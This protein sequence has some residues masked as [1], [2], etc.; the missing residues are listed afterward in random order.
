[1]Q[2]L[3]DTS[4]VSLMLREA[5]PR[6]RKRLS[7]TPMQDLC[8]S[9][10]TEAELRYGLARRGHPAGL[11]QRVHELLLRLESLPWTSEVAQ[12]YAVLRSDSDAAGISLGPLDMMIAAHARAVDATL[13]SA[14]RAFAR[15]H[16]LLRVQDWSD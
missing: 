14:D 12:T 7:R 5:G 9:L 1:M 10:V 13:V 3:L 6:F 8:I 16:R 2:Y 4:T 11:T 15:L